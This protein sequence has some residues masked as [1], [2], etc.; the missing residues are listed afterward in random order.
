MYFIKRLLLF[1]PMAWLISLLAFALSEAAPGDPVEQRCLGDNTG[2]LSPGEYLLCAKKHGFDKPAFYLG[3]RARAYPDTLYKI[4]PLQRRVKIRRLIAQTAWAEPVFRWEERLQQLLRD[5]ALSSQALK[6]IEAL[7]R[8][9][10][11]SEIEKALKQLQENQE[12]LGREPHLAKALEQISS[13]FRQ[14]QEKHKRINLYLPALS[15]HGLDN[16]YH[17]WLKHLLQGN[18]GISYY[19][20]QPVLKKIRPALFWTVLINFFAYLLAFLIAIPLGVYMAVHENTKFDKTVSLVLF[21]L[22]ALPRFWTATLLLTFFTTAYYASWLDLFPGPGLG[23]LSA[24][25][26]TIKRLAERSAHLVLPVFCLAYPLLAF[27]ARQMRSS[28]INALQSEYVLAARARGLSER[29]IIWKHA[30]RNAL[31]PIITIAASVLPASVAGSVVI[32]QIFAIPGMGLLMYESIL[33]N[34][35]PVVFAILLLGA[36]LTMLGLLLADL[37]YAGVNPRVRFKRQGK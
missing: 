9:E 33:R 17:Q 28:M 11:I 14:M 16:R 23:D 20:K 31:F 5:S 6:K 26:P 15:W 25:A 1:F 2:A 8:L 35:W 19:D 24:S 36:L 30:F 21:G 34:D 37:L 13:A 27:I 4:L 3:L 10:Q 18:P 7:Y 22:Y 12:L 29:R 32:E